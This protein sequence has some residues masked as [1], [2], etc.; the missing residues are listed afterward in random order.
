MELYWAKLTEFLNNHP[1][2]TVF[3][4]QTKLA[5]AQVIE[6]LGQ[7]E[8]DLKGRRSRVARDLAEIDASLKKLAETRQSLTT[9]SEGTVS[10]PEEAEEGATTTAIVMKAV[11]ANPGL[12]SSELIDKLEVQLAH[13]AA[14]D[15]RKLVT[16]T[17]GY[18][19]SKSR[20]WKE[21]GRWFP[22]GLGRGEF[23][24]GT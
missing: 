15:K 19:W 7:E 5:F 12:T 8:A 24:I 20:V 11:N 2:V 22:A 10:K 1:E 14:T 21:D 18:L 4:P 16:S 6:A 23:V 9:M 3:G 13:S 17:L